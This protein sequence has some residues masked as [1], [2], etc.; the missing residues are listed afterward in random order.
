MAEQ[1]GG[2]GR[3]ARDA[4][5]DVPADPRAG[6]PGATPSGGEAGQGDEQA[7]Q[8]DTPAASNEVGRVGEP[9]MG[10]GGYGNDT[11]F[12]GGT[13]GATD[14]GA[15]GEAGGVEGVEGAGEAGTNAPDRGM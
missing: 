7:G 11:G 6:A 10:K 9:R 8:T 3:V 13:V 15:A 1:S 2:G 4:S 5:G 14:G 12:V